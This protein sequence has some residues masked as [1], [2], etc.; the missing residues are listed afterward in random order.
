LRHLE[1]KIREYI[2]RVVHRGKVDC[3]FRYHPPEMQ[4]GG[5]TIDNELLQVL[6]DSAKQ[7]EQQL[8][9]STPMRA[10]DFLRWPGVL[11]HPEQD[12]IELGTSSL[13]LLE[14]VLEDVAATRQREGEQLRKAIEIRCESM[15]NQLIDLQKRLPIVIKAM[16]SRLMDRLEELKSNVDVDRLE[17]EMLI[18]ANRSDISEEIDRLNTHIKEVRRVLSQDQP[19]GRRLD[20]LMQELNREA[21]TVGSKSADSQTTKI[22]VELK[23]L[24]EQVREQVQN[25]E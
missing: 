3:S 20:F 22:A 10:S 2:G 1:P 4:D 23:V 15:E 25:I 11:T 19:I 6:I 24:I 21:N 8:G 14:L 9:E 17:Q 5:A 16:R 7:V 13:K 18:L 12:M